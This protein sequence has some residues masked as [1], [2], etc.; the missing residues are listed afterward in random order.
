[1]K[2]I[3]LRGH[4]RPL[5]CVKTNKHGDLLFTCGKDAI[6]A[7]W[8]TDNGQQIGRYNC[9]RGAVW[10]CDITLNSKYLLAAS[11][12][13]KVLLFDALKGTTLLEIQEEGPCKYVEWN[14]NPSAQNKFVVVHDDFSDSVKMALKLYEVTP[15][16]APDGSM[17]LG[18]RV[19]WIQ[20]G[21][22]NRCH[23]CH[24][25]PLDKTVV[26]AHEDGQIN[27]WSSYDGMHLRTLDAHKG[28]VTSLAFDL[29]SL[30]MLSCSSDGTAKLW[31]T[32]MWTNIKS[33]KTDRPL[34]ACDISPLFNVE[35]GT[36]AHILLGGG[37]EA[38]QVTTTAASEGKFQALIY[39]LIHEEEVGSIKGH[40]GP[41]N[42][43]TFLADGTGY[44]SGGE[45]GFVRIY[46]FDREYALDKYD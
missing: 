5:T 24:W 36:K 43:L 42:T 14:K 3:I 15:T 45:D 22:R 11:G 19:I 1:M 29:Y 18:S 35:D 9:G 39:N 33:Y 10:G 44:V 31:E 34:N 4:H 23:Q 12:D 30:L 37:Q 6:L 32:A 21:Y 7:L 2:P 46:H 28:T 41:I 16:T 26:T 20:R 27:V 13:S 8:R 17:E 38:D 25:G 40:F